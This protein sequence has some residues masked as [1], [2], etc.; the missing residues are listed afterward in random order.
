MMQPDNDGFE[1]D[2][3]EVEAEA[4]RLLE[5][6]RAEATTQGL[7]HAAFYFEQCEARFLEAA[8]RA[9]M[10]LPERSPFAYAMQ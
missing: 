5:I 9:Q 4:R 10:E 3:N 2:N 7:P 6:L 1:H 8:R